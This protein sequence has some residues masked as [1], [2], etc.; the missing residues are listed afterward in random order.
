MLDTGMLAVRLTRSKLKELFFYPQ[1]NAALV[2]G[3]CRQQQAPKL[4]C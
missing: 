4:E 1:S 2:A 3:T